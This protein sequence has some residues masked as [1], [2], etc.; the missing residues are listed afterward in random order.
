MRTPVP[1]FTNAAGLK[2]EKGREV[3][4]R[5]CGRP[6]RVRCRGRSAPAGP[7][8][9]RPWE[10]AR[11]PDTA[12]EGRASGTATRGA[13]ARPHAR[14]ACY[15]SRTAGGGAGRAWPA[16]PEERNCV[17]GRLRPI[18]GA[19]LP[20]RRE[21]AAPRGRRRPHCPPLSDSGL[22]GAGEKSG[23][24]AEERAQPT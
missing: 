8:M 11:G 13:T 17:G 24:G 7:G 10:R 16:A 15:P 22:A 21:A 6:K 2:A 12:R 14:A 23:E 4:G 19:P 3:T 18:G 20:G 5:R 9:A 1:W